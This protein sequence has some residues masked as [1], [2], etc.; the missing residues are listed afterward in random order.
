MTFTRY[1]DGDMP[2]KQYSDVLQRIYDKPDF[3]LSL[4]EENKRNLKSQIAYK[5]SKRT[6]LEVIGVKETVSSKIDEVINYLLVRCE[7]IT[8]LAL[9]K[10]LYYIQG[11][12]Y[13]FM[14]SFL[15]T[16]DC[17]A[18]CTVR[19]IGKS[20]TAIPDT[21]LIRLKAMMSLMF[22]YLRIR[23]K[24]LLTV[25]FRTYAVTVGKYWSALHTPKC[26]G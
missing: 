14:G 3:Y 19:F 16:E 21:D 12:Y 20:I 11:F 15:F 25:L 18:W 8:P 22:P 7:D 9:Q 1:C 23:K 5:K 26:L 2:T 24:P 6:T 13:A 10:A 4:L 17:E